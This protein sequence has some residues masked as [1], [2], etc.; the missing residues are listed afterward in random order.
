MY[1]TVMDRISVTQ[2]FGELPQLEFKRN[3]QKYKKLQKLRQTEICT[4]T[5][6]Y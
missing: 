3:G 6:L 4:L 2:L 5:K 1:W